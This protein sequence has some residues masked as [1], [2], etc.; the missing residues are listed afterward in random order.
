MTSDS[1][2]VVVPQKNKESLK[3]S[4]QKVENFDSRS[5]ATKVPLLRRGIRGRV[6]IA[7]AVNDRK[8]SSSDNVIMVVPQKKQREPEKLPEM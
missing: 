3:S 4:L 7:N 6:R 8:R 2:E 1:V 5:E